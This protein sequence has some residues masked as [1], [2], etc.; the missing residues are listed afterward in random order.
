VRTVQFLLLLGDSF[1][2]L[3]RRDWNSGA[4]FSDDAGP[5]LRKTPAEAAVI[6]SLILGIFNAAGDFCGPRFGLH[7]A[8]E[9][10]HGVFCRSV[11][12][13]PSDSKDCGERELACILAESP[14][15]SS[16]CTAAASQRSRHFSLPI[17]FGPE[18]VGA[19]HGATLTAWSAAAVAGPVIITELSNRAKSGWR[20]GASKTHVYDTPLRSSRCTAC[21]G[22]RPDV[23][24]EAAGSSGKSPADSPASLFALSTGSGAN[25]T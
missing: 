23:A 4:G 19:I 16:R 10:V 18:N 13:V 17:F 14:S 8:A 6:V 20:A 7:R 1:C 12:P 15:S 9:H 21:S 24:A 25:V 5:V 2:Q 22:I 11:F 3:S